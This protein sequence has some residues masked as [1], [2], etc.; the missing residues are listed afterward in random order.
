M[1]FPFHK[2]CSPGQPR[3]F[4]ASRHFYNL[5]T[6]QIF[7]IENSPPQQCNPFYP[8]KRVS[9]RYS[10][11]LLFLKTLLPNLQYYRIVEEKKQYS[12]AGAASF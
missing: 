12:G 4:S 11:L 8:L 7:K 10:L 3:P 5:I 6:F 9:Y 1:W 2:F